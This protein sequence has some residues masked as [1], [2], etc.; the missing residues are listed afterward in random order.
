MNTFNRKLVDANATI[1]EMCAETGADP[2]NIVMFITDEGE[3]MIVHMRDWDEMT[4][5]KKKEMVMC[6]MV[7]MRKMHEVINEEDNATR[8]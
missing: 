5:D 8:N 7:V 3:D 6:L 2:D 4:T 1:A